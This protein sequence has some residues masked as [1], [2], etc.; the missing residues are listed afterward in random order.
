ML[1]EVWAGVDYRNLAAADHVGAGTSEC[2]GARVA[3]HDAT[4]PR[5]DRLQPAV[6]ERELATKRDVDSHGGE[7]TR[8]PRH[9]TGLT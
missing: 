3:R 2:E 5:C 8:D 1:G 9:A 6:F 4:D 7:T